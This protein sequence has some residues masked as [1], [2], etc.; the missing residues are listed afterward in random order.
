MKNKKP[1]ER[2][3]IPT[4]SGEILAQLAQND[5]NRQIKSAPN[6]YFFW[7]CQIKFFS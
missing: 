7:L 5:E 6:L 3:L 1:H 2:V 4:L